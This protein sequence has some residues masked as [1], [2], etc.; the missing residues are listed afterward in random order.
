MFFI[1]ILKNVFHKSRFKSFSVVVPMWHESNTLIS[2]AIGF[3]IKRSFKNNDDLQLCSGHIRFRVEYSGCKATF[4]AFK[5][6][7][8]KQDN[9]HLTLCQL[10]VYG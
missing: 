1:N 7:T 2:S 6:I 4:H 3:Y 9:D 10:N 5:R 8:I